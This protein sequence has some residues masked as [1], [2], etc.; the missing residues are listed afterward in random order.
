MESVESHGHVVKIMAD[1]RAVYLV[2]SAPAPLPLLGLSLDQ[3]EYDHL[4]RQHCYRSP[5]ARNEM[6]HALGSFAFVEQFAIASLQLREDGLHYPNY[7]RHGK[8]SPCQM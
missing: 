3:S 4:L 5:V 8:N 1:L 7:L 6:S 2:R